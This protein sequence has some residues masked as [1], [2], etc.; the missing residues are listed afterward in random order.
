MKGILYG[1]GVGSESSEGL[2]I[3]ALETIKKC[4]V[5]VFP[6]KSRE[7]CRAYQIVNS[8]LSGLESKKL[9]F[10][11]FPMTKDKKSLAKAWENYNKPKIW[12]KNSKNSEFAVL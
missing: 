5:I 10:Y 4:D 2:S 9:Y 6:N 7:D 12:T 11:D 1:I 3:K 8:N